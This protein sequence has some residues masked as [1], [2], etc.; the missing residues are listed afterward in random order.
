VKSLKVHTPV[1]RLGFPGRVQTANFVRSSLRSRLK[2]LPESRWRGLSSMLMRAVR[3]C[4]EERGGGGESGSGHADEARSTH[5]VG[6]GT[7]EP[8]VRSSDASE[9]VVCDIGGLVST[10]V[11]VDHD[12]DGGA[13]FDLEE[14][15]SI[16]GLLVSKPVVAG[17]MTLSGGRRGSLSRV[18]RPRGDASAIVGGGP[19]TSALASLE[20]GPGWRVSWPSSRLGPVRADSSRVPGGDP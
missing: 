5:G 16:V 3:R 2:R 11:D 6:E 7:N 8:V 15:G 13:I 1:A 18:E 10:A 19:G 9:V 20:S 17:G 14:L 12:L 4:S